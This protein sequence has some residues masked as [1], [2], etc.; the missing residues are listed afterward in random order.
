MPQ[1]FWPRWYISRRRL[2]PTRTDPSGL[3]RGQHQEGNDHRQDD[4]QENHGPAG[5]RHSP[6]CSEP[7]AKGPGLPGSRCLA[8]TAPC[9]IVGQPCPAL[10][11]EVSRRRAPDALHC[12]LRDPLAGGSLL[13]SPSAALV[14]PIPNRARVAGGRFSR[15][16]RAA[17]GAARL[18]LA[19]VAGRRVR[20]WR[21]AL[22]HGF[23][24]TGPTL[25]SLVGYRHAA[26]R[27]RRHPSHLAP[28]LPLPLARPVN[29]GAV[30]CSLPPSL[31]HRFDPDRL[32]R[33]PHPRMAAMA[34]ATTMHSTAELVATMQQV[35]SDSRLPGP[36]NTWS[37]PSMSLRRHLSQPQ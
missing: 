22:Q 19:F 17:P 26:L 13:L 11:A 32:T 35:V 25:R 37:P 27:A 28:S 1:R 2:P 20:A 16:C 31:R 8:H 18:G 7:L 14:R 21:A 3:G 30:R 9:A 6:C 10:P 4:N 29:L 36:P 33:Q 5:A 34:A 12:L 15:Q 23:R 24:R